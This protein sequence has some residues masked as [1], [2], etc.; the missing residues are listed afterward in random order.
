MLMRG[1]KRK[2]MVKNKEA[3]ELLFHPADSHT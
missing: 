3:P 2:N 1:K